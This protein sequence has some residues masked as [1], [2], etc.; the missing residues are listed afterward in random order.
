MCNEVACGAGVADG[1][2]V[3]VVCCWLIGGFICVVDVFIIVV[4]TREYVETISIAVATR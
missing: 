3:S 1:C 2:G 4:E